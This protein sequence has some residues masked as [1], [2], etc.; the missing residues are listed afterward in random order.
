[1]QNWYIYKSSPTQLKCSYVFIKEQYDVHSPERDCPLEFLTYGVHLLANKPWRFG[2]LKFSPLYLV[3]KLFQ[4]KR[5]AAYILAEWRTF[6]KVHWYLLIGLNIWMKSLL[7]FC[8]LYDSKRS[9]RKIKAQHSQD[10]TNII[11]SQELLEWRIDILNFPQ[12]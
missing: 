6:L 2:N 1:M 7:T 9:F 5:M 12:C 11:P 3:I 8:L 10:G 4:M